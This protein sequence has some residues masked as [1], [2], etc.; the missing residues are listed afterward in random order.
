MLIGQLLRW[1]LDLSVVQIGAWIPNSEQERGALRDWTIRGSDCHSDVCLPWQF[2]FSDVKT[3]TM[4]DLERH[5]TVL[6]AF[7]KHDGLQA[8]DRTISDCVA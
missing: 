4:T 2:C 6:I 1:H 7:S 3:I 5:L 8:C